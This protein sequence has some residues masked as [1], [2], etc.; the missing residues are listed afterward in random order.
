MVIMISIATLVMVGL[1]YYAYTRLGH[2][3]MLDPSKRRLLKL[4][5]GSLFVMMFGSIFLPRSLGVTPARW[6]SWTAYIWLG[7]LVVLCVVLV[8]G[9][10][11]RLAVATVTWAMQRGKPPLVDD[12]RR[13]L[14]ARALG[15][16]TLGTAGTLIGYSLYQ[17]LRRVAVRKLAVTLQKLPAELSGFRIVQITD[18]HVGPTIDGQWLRRMVE[19]VNAL[20]PDIIAITGD[21]VDGPVA[22]LRDHVAPIGELRARHG[23]FFVTGNHEYYAGVDSWLAELA[24]LGVRVLR[25][26]RVTVRPSDKA[27]S[28]ACIDILGVDDYHS[29][30]FPGHGPDLP[31]AVAGRDQKNPAI[32]LAHQPAAIAEAARHGVDL[33]LSGHTHGGQIWPWDFLFACS[34]PTSRACTR[35]AIP[36]FM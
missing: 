17:G 26:E 20:N 23:V 34:N 10:L 22:R 25:N 14:I 2:H 33:Q 27:G 7:S 24:R 30:T 32:L 5:V 28:T 13:T 36:S 16:A 29:A 8:G 4:I 19:Q 35:T 9:D 6:M 21:L 31:K 18:I 3:L 12:D 1:H 15:V 11:A